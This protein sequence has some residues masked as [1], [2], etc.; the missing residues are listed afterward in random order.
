LGYV[1]CNVWAGFGFP[2]LNQLVKCKYISRSS[3]KRCPK[4]NYIFIEG[5]IHC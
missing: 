4:H 5:I 2:Q 1:L 3:H